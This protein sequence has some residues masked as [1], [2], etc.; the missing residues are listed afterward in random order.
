MPWTQAALDKMDVVPTLLP[1]NKIFILIL[2]CLVLCHFLNV[3]SRILQMFSLDN[4]DFD[5]AESA[6]SNE[7]ISEGR[8][9]VELARRR[10]SEDCVLNF[11][12]DRTL[13]LELNDRYDESRAI[14]LRMQIARLIEEGTLPQD[15]G[16]NGIGLECEQSKL[17][18][19]QGRK[20]DDSNVMHGSLLETRKMGG[21]SALK[22][23][24]SASEHVSFYRN[25]FEVHLQHCISPLSQA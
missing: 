2:L 7:T 6:P 21:S 9:L 20:C 13:Q 24:T 4:L 17:K 11:V 14:P 15:L 18:S 3:Y 16:E 23:C 10:R 5:I 19:S 1:S 12:R 25:S 8:R 22:L